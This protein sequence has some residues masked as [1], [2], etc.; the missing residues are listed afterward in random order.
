MQRGAL[1]KQTFLK[2]SWSNDRSYMTHCHLL[3]SGAYWGFFSMRA[4]VLLWQH[5]AFSA[6]EPRYHPLSTSLSWRP[7]LCHGDNCIAMDCTAPRR[8]WICHGDKMHQRHLRQKR[9][10]HRS[11]AHITKVKCQS[12]RSWSN[13]V[14]FKRTSWSHFVEIKYII[15]Q[16]TSKLSAL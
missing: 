7:W 4:L 5:V 8:K 6:E 16:I 11:L 9:R 15:R 10:S 1:V 2:C 12:G 3:P 14:K 13:Y